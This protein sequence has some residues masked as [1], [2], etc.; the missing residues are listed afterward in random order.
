MSCPRCHCA[1]CNC[2]VTEIRAP[3]PEAR[4]YHFD[5]SARGDAAARGYETLG[6]TS[7]TPP[8]PGESTVIAVA[9]ATRYP[10][11]TCVK[12]SD[13]THSAVM[14]VTGWNADRDAIYVLGYNNAEN[15]G[16]TM[17]GG[18]NIFSLAICPVETEAGGVVCDRDFMVTAEAFVMPAAI[19]SGGGTVKVVFDA[20]Q[21]LQAGMSLVIV[22]AGYMEVSVPP[23]GVFVA[24]GTDFYCYNSGTVGNAG[25]GTNIPAGAAAYPQVPL[26]GTS[27]TPAA[28]TLLLAFGQSATVRAIEA[29]GSDPDLSV[30]LDDVKTDDIVEVYGEMVA[31]SKRLAADFE[32]VSGS[33]TR[34]FGIVLHDWDGSRE[35][36]GVFDSGH[37]ESITH[38][39]LWKATADGSLEFRWKWAATG[40]AGLG[41]ARC[42]FS[43]RDRNLM[44][45]VIGNNP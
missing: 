4:I 24:C 36:D 39:E 22:G 3:A 7:W 9:D 5:S 44:V 23:S 34:V 11:G 31:R 16:G 2:N 8:G 25:A 27:A 10:V 14:R 35:V 37:D 30:T 40:A 32:L 42:H 13:G 21:T 29:A 6:V 43:L 17:S 38:R 28:Q 19:T 15:T 1:S 45:R 12:V 26:A 33:A 18:L 41:G 20:P